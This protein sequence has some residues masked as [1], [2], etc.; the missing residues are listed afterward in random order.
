MASKKRGQ[1][2]HTNDAMLPR[3]D[4]CVWLAKNFLQP[5]RSTTQILV[6]MRHQYRISALS[7]FSLII[8]FLGFIWYSFQGCQQKSYRV[9]IVSGFVLFFE[10]IIQGLF[11]DF[12]SH[13]SHFS[14]TSN[15]IQCKKEPWVYVS[16][17]SFSTG[18]IL[19]Q[20]FLCVCSFFFGIL[21]KL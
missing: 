12:R 17:S 5:I 15:L 8:F 19:S 6:V 21:L 16:S 18:V 14:G 4:W 7:R 11:K 13:I 1:K 10:Q 3:S 2:F 9:Y 20:G